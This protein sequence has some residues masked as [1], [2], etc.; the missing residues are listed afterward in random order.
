[1]CEF[2]TGEEGVKNG[3]LLFRRGREHA[4]SMIKI[5]QKDVDLTG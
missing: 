4:A 2:T 3:H 5:T 1:M